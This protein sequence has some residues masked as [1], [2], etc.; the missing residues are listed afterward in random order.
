MIFVD[1][2]LLWNVEVW[3]A[4]KYVDDRIFAL[5]GGHTEILCGGLAGTI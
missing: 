5:K 4:H 2:V 1:K 3:S